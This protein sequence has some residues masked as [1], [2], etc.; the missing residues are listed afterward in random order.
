KDGARSP[1][2]VV[3]VLAAISLVAIGVRFWRLS[4]GLASG[5]YFPDE[6]GVWASYYF[7]FRTPSLASLFGHDLNYPTLH[8]YLV[9]STVALAERFGWIGPG[10]D[11]L[12]AIQV[13]R[14]ISAVLGLFT[15]AVVGRLAWSAYG[16]A[17][18]L[19]AAALMAIAPF[20]VIQTHFV[21]VD[22]LL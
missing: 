12:G 2:V 15:V 17:A 3:L 1:W 5:C 16:A 21:S 11:Y 19:L 9:G 8:G 20:E 22:I 7:A 13:A 10:R 4:Y 18:G 6:R 14:C